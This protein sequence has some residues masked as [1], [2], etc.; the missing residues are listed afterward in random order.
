MAYTGMMTT[1]TNTNNQRR[2]V[3]DRLVLASPYDIAAIQ[4][5][6]LDNTAKF[7][8]VDT[9][10]VQYTWYEDTYVPNN[11]T[12]AAA[13]AS[14]SATSV[15]VSTI[16]IYQPG[17]VIKVDDEYM[18]VSST[19]NGAS[20]TVTRGFGGT[21]ATT[22]NSGAEVKILYSARTEGAVADDSPYSEITQNT[23][24]STILEYT[25]SAARSDMRIKRYGMSDIIEYYIDKGMDMLKE[26]LNRIAYYGKKSSNPRS[27][28]GFNEFIATNVVNLSGASL[29]RKHLD[30]M[31]ERIFSYGGNPDLILCSTW[32]RRKINSF[33]EPFITTERD[34]RVGGM[35]IDT[36]EHPF[37]GVPITIVTD[38]HCQQD[39]LYLIDRRYAGY[40]TIDPFFYEPLAKTG[41][42]EQG[43]IVGEYGFVVQF[44]K[45]HGILKG[46]S[47]TS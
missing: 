34:E 24:Y 13:I 15:S 29:T 7:K 26:R 9:P 38:R 23:N 27:S 31:L 6:G 32:A 8:F 16:S 25:V 3:T 17:D 46:F 11:D 37:G 5:L 43:Q 1:Y 47:T 45:A 39:Y 19:N 18:W 12:L 2:T 44:E 4:A 35:R 42:S 36:L 22:H 21:T 10:G 40:I 30:D 33:F 41:D 28:G 14:S 20:L